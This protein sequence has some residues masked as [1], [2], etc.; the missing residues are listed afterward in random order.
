MEGERKGGFTFRCDQNY[1]RC[2]STEKTLLFHHNSVK[3]HKLLGLPTC[4][5]KYGKHLLILRQHFYLAMKVSC[6]RKSI[7]NNSL[8]NHTS[9]T[10]E[11]VYS[12]EQNYPLLYVDAISSTGIRVVKNFYEVGNLATTGL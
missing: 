1:L 8:V 3:Q 12:S 9:L 2:A 10:L 5:P 7:P 4:T 6:I 11:R